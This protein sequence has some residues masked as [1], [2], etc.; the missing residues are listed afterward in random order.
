M[1]FYL[2]TY[3]C[4]LNQADSEMIRG[5][6]L[7]NRASEA[8]NEEKADVVIINTCTVKGSTEQKTLEYA[9]RLAS[10]GKKL[11]IAGCI[12]QANLRLVEKFI[13]SA[14]I[15]GPFSLA[16]IYE[17]SEGALQGRKLVFLEHEKKSFAQER[18][19]VIARIP[20]AEGCLGACAYC[21]T[22][23]ARGN[24][25][26]YEQK[27]IVKEISSLLKRGF[28]EFQ[29]T[30]QDTGAYGKDIG[31]S[32]ISLLC[33]LASLRGN[34]RLRVGMCNPEHALSLKSFANSFASKNIYKFIHLPV[35]SGSNRVL[36]EM[37]RKYTVAQFFRVINSFRVHFPQASIATD[38]IVGYP[39]ETERDFK[40]SLALIKKLQPNVVNVSKFTPR[41]L[42][43]AAKL[44]M[45]SPHVIN[46]RSVKM[47]ALCRELTEQ[48]NR[49]LIG[50][51]F[52]V[53]VTE[54]SRGSLKGRTNAY[55]QMVIRGKAKLGE[56]VKV[57]VTEATTTSL[58]GETL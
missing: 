55:N 49:A 28:K 41:P 54:C 8:E 40:L 13:P 32:L 57:R 25:S 31:S 52:E 50:K 33:E 38:I 26:S 34:F 17:A 6:M 37:G 19:G 16:H 5:I 11:V 2:R 4:T 21:Q 15:V 56:F 47:S 45:L 36:K 58:I 43:R 1:R 14:C 29:L 48:K 3:G 44:T 9:K 46:A 23:L 18:S 39:T 12:P 35:Q 53:L 27:A 51:E 10:S 30:A 22:K 24:L 20:I 42:T 7:K